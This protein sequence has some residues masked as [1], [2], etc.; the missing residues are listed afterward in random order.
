[1]FACINL[2]LESDLMT[3]LEKIFNQREGCRSPDYQIM[4]ATDNSC[5]VFE[6]RDQEMTPT[7]GPSTQRIIT[8]LANEFKMYDPQAA[9]TQVNN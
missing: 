1:M 2:N 9:E 6:V 8:P 3:A 4:H 5:I 7:S